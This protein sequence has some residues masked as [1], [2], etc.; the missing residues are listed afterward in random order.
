M[1]DRGVQRDPRSQDVSSVRLVPVQVVLHVPDAVVRRWIL[2]TAEEQ[3]GD[4]LKADSLAGYQE[5]D[6]IR[7]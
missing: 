5:E 3:R 6:R 2:A 1:R 4:L 7:F